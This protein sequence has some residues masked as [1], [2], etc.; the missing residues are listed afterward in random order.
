MREGKG[1][2]LPFGFSRPNCRTRAGFVWH[3]ADPRR[4]GNS[5][6]QPRLSAAEKGRR[7]PRAQ[8]S[9][10]SRRRRVKPGFFFPPRDRLI[11]V[12][13]QEEV[14]GATTT[15][16]TWQGEE[17]GWGRGRGVRGQLRGKQG[18]G[19][20]REGRRSKKTTGRNMEAEDD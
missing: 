8:I 1:W 15:T 12:G 18:G 9:A 2:R 20:A 19:S 7:I 14:L 11:Q 5:P 10:A 6:T 3:H 13:G 16:T 4:H 17:G